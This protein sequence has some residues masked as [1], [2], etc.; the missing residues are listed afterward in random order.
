M[1][2]VTHS[3]KPEVV[4]SRLARRIEVKRFP[5]PPPSALRTHA[6]GT[7]T[8]FVFPSRTLLV[9]SQGHSKASYSILFET[10]GRLR[11]ARLGVP[12]TG[13]IPK[14]M[15]AIEFLQPSSWYR[16]V[17]AGRRHKSRTVR[18]GQLIYILITRHDT[19]IR[20]VELV[21]ERTPPPAPPARQPT[22]QTVDVFPTV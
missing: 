4:N 2:L 21:P 5:F 7:N 8:D 20:V 13:L 22:P 17:T 3:L 15:R 9:T 10:E 19:L 14:L 1:R 18:H 12:V 6:R 16:W 11:A